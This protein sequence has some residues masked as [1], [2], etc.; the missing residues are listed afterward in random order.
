MNNG[1]LRELCTAVTEM[2]AGSLS[3]GPGNVDLQEPL[4]EAIYTPSLEL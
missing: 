2:M 1:S 4:T 3:D